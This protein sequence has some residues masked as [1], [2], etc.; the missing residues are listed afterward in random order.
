MI[1][2]YF[3]PLADVLAWANT[4]TSSR[5]PDLVINDGDRQPYLERWHLLPKMQAGGVN[6]HRILRSDKDVPHDHPWDNTTFVLDGEMIDESAAGR[7]LLRPG[8]IVHRVAEGHHRLILEPGMVVTTMFFMQE[9]RRDWGFHCPK[10]FV[11]WRDFVD[12]KHE[13]RVGAGCGEYA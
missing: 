2:P 12:S 4:I 13:G 10:G 1:D 8:D 7:R 3:A 5:P 9:R 11:P 6:I